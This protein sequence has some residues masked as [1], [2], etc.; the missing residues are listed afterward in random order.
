MIGIMGAVNEELELYIH[1]LSN[2]KKSTYSGFDFYSGTLG[3]KDVVVVKSGVGKVNSGICS[4]ILI[5]RFN[6]ST[7][8]FTGV[9]GA[10]NPELEI[11]DLVISKDCVQHDM[12]ATGLGFEKGQIPFTELRFFK[13]SER[14][15]KL[16]LSAAKKTNL[17]AI[18]GRV[19]TGDQFLTDKTKASDIKDEFNGDCVDMEG[20]A[21]AQ[22]CTLNDVPFLVIKS[23]SD[24]A[25]HSAE[26]NFNKFCKTAAKNSFMIVNEIIKELEM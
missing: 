2:S 14:L 22:V 23:I 11:E 18:D 17:R 20:A 8:I 4:Q 16:A 3:G 5:D 10:L 1:N 12:D 26:I 25:D 24:K 15:R 7:V 21:M 19:L 6:A 9:A 13:A